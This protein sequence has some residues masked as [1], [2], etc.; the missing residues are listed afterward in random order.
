M[1]KAPSIAVARTAAPLQD[2]KRPAAHRLRGAMPRYAMVADALVADIERGTYSVGDLLPGE[3]EI[4]QQYGLSRHTTREAL[5]RL[6]EMGLITRRPGIGTI[7]KARATESHYTAVIAD[8]GDLI[9][10]TKHTR[11]QV[12]DQEWVKVDGELSEFLQ[13]AKGKRW[14]KLTTLRFPSQS[15]EPISYTQILLHPIYEVIC[16][17]LNE[18]GATVFGL[19]EELDGERVKELKQEVSCLAAS[20]EVAALLGVSAGD[21]VLNVVRSYYGRGDALL[22]VSLNIYPQNR[23]KV[24]THWRL[25]SNPP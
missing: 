16:E 17:R 15:K 12:L 8:P 9:H 23:F 18:P 6:E 14:I 4:A 24:T 21:P 2:R 22:S 19:I 25:D 1:K 7:V 11:L 10:H 5:R 20:A 3:L 13:G